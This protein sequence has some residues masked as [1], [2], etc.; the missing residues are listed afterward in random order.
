MYGGMTAGQGLGMLWG[1]GEGIGQTLAAKSLADDSRDFQKLVMKK[2]IRWRMNDMRKAGINPILAARPGGIT[3]A[4]STGAAPGRSSGVDG[5]RAGSAASLV[6]AQHELLREQTNAAR[7][8][9]GA[10]KAIS[11]KEWANA[12]AVE[13]NNTARQLD[14]DFYGT[15]EGREFRKWERRIKTVTGGG[16]VN[17]LRLR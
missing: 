13:L 15:N 11:S 12:R 9:A 16:A 1:T 7:N 14:S 5:L 17:P 6:R 4:G 10:Q 3:G 8:T 2:Q